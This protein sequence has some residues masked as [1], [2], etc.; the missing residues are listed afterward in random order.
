MNKILSLPSEYVGRDG[1]RNKI[2]MEETGNM[3]KYGMSKSCG[4]SEEAQL[5]LPVEVKE[6]S[7][8]EITFVS[9]FGGGG[10]RQGRRIGVLHTKGRK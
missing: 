1:D 6:D 4:S 2:L 9:V 5:T 3:P 8:E 10:R 7:R